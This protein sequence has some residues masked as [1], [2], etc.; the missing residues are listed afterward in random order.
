MIDF[1][2]I[3][4]IIGQIVILM[5]M[6]QTTYLSLLGR[7]P[8]LSIAELEQVFT[9]VSPHGDEA[10]TFESLV[11]PD[12]QRL[13]GSTKIGEV[14]AE[15]EPQDWT[16]VSKKIVQ[17]YGDRLAGFDGKVTIG[18]SVYGHDVPVRD[19]QRTG[20]TLKSAL[21]KHG[22]SMRLIPNDGPALSTAT[23]HHNKLG[24]SSNKLELLVV[25]SKESVLI[26]ESLGT[27]NITALA[28][29]DQARPKTDAFVGML[30]PKLA[31]M[32]INLSGA[33]KLSSQRD[34]IVTRPL[35]A[36]PSERSPVQSVS[37]NDT[38]EIDEL[39][40]L[41]ILDPFCGTGVVLQEA[42]L[43]GFDVYGTDLSEKM[44]DYSTANIE[45]L[46]NKYPVGSVR[47]EAGDAVEHQW[48]PPVNAVVAETY[49][50]QPFSAPPSQ[51][52]LD[53]VL[54]VVDV[55]VSKFLANIHDQLEPGTPLCLAVPAWRSATGWFTYLP[56]I[57]KI[58]SLGYQWQL[59]ENVDSQKLTYF[60]ENQVVARQLLILKTK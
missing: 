26:A 22:V 47:I 59:L 19:V 7:Q 18:I 25:Y 14:V 49:L 3:L 36:T 40:K 15:L 8:E 13:G 33:T 30:P 54:K 28:A 58:E 12:V 20:L 1:T 11:K 48:H 43:L 42:A 45:W 44:V 60:R 17:Y 51:E 6:S 9:G 56:V 21:K 2:D 35:S 46:G 16:K 38:S 24:L 5:I 31:L 53:K 4:P 41:T 37:G 55:I 57:K 10:A 52:K 23:A 32:M 34:D 39:D 27:Q 50:G 29:R